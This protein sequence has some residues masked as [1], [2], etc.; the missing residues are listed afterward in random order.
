MTRSAQK[1]REIAYAV[2]AGELLEE[3]WQVDLPPDE[4][5][6]PD[7]VITGRLGAFG[8]EVRE[9]YLDETTKGSPKKAREA[10]SR[11]AMHDLA[12]AYYR[13][14]SAPISVQLLGRIP[15]DDEVL[16]LLANETKRLRT[17]EQR[18]IDVGSGCVAYMRK[19]PDS[20][21]NYSTW[22]F[23]SNHVGWV[24]TIDKRLLEDIIIGKAAR[25]GRYRKHI[26]DVRLLIVSDRLY[27]SG[28]A[29]LSA[30]MK[31]HPRGFDAVYY[32]SFPETVW[33]IG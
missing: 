6:W 25:L 33:R 10:H 26:P 23:A 15:A 16:R 20:C 30:P 32:L 29:R 5:N 14:N 1:Q 2:K 22:H 7:L 13:D 3:E 17:W 31:C 28:M 27:N 24:A 12:R 21:R 11:R 8:L 9:L 18:R 4:S 19:L